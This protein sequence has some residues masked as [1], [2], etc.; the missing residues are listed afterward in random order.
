MI[1]TK[2]ETYHSESEMRRE[3]AKHERNG[4][5]VASVTRNGQGYS[6]VKTAAL[7]LVFLPLALLGKKK[8]VFQ[9]IYQYEGQIVFGRVIPSKK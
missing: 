8:D 2:V 4:F 1:K 6:L 9:V 5:T 7:G 3:I